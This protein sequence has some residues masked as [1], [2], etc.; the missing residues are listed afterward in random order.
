M[1]YDLST[2][3]TEFVEIYTEDR[4]SYKRSTDVENKD[5]NEAVN[6]KDI[7]MRWVHIKDST[8]VDMVAAASK[9]T[10]DD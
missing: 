6:Q 5:A 10:G 2:F 7:K 9:L 8:P 3:T 4:D 1:G